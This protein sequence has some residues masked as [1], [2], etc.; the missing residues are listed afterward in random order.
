MRRRCV[1]YVT[2][3][4]LWIPWAYGLLARGEGVE[5]N[6]V[7]QIVD[8]LAESIRHSSESAHAHANR[9]VGARCGVFFLQP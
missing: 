5:D 6:C 9:Q 8:F 4:V 1:E 7:A 2:L 3:A